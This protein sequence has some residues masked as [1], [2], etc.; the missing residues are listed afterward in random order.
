LAAVQ[1]EH[2]AIAAEYQRDLQAWKDKHQRDPTDE[3]LVEAHWAA[4]SE[5]EAQKD[6]EKQDESFQKYL[7][8]A[9]STAQEGVDVESPAVEDNPQ[10]VD[11]SDQ[12][13]DLPF[14][15]GYHGSQ[16]SS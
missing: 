4:Y 2:A 6:W 3:E 16:N 10:V 8:E 5:A 11:Y 7:E 14:L 1:V 13:R 9:A 12:E 15:P